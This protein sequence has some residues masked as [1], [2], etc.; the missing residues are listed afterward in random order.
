MYTQPILPQGFLKIEFI[1]RETKQVVGQHTFKNLITNRGVLLFA[2]SAISNLPIVSH[3][4]IGDGTGTGSIVNPEAANTGGT[5]LRNE[6]VR[7]PLDIVAF[8]LDDETTGGPLFK[9]G[10]RSNKIVVSGVINAL[11]DEGFSFT[12]AALFGGP[13]ANEKNGGDMFNWVTFSQVIKPGSV[14]T[15]IS[16]I[17]VFPINGEYAS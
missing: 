7:V 5:L 14:D 15:V 12:E 2:Q 16:W 9:V 17:I 13:G 3:L 6:I 10:D 8:S 11:Q 4:A 1:D